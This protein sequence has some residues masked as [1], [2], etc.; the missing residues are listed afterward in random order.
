M[1]LPSPSDPTFPYSF[2]PSESISNK[3]QVKSS[4]ARGIR[5]NI[6][7]QYPDFEQY[8]DDCIPKKDNIVIGKWYSTRLVVFDDI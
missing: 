3:S 6:L 2:I 8:M 1:S 5:K 7:E 4:V